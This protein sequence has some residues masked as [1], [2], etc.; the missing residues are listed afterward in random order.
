VK[1]RKE[2]LKIIFRRGCL[3]PELVLRKAL[4]LCERY[5]RASDIFEFSGNVM[6]KSD[7]ISWP[8]LTEHGSFDVAANGFNLDFGNPSRQKFSFLLVESQGNAE[9]DWDGWMAEFMGE[10]AFIMAWVADVEYDHWQNAEDPLNYTAVGKPYEHLPMK[11]NGLP[12]PLEQMI[13]DTSANPGRWRYRG[14]YAEAVGA[15]MWLGSPFWGLTG[16]DL[17]RV[18]AERDLQVSRPLP[19]VTRIKTAESCFTSD[20][21][22]EG[23]LQEK[24]RSLLFPSSA[25]R[26]QGTLH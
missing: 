23:R 7:I 11:S 2:L 18:A 21:G 22:A 15:M 13:V 26:G 10:S 25:E 3:A 14:D 4:A 5:G 20:A 8:S 12:Y 16:A 24:L 17:D 6:R 19:S 1:V 9:V